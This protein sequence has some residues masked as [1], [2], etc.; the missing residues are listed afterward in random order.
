MKIALVLL[1]VLLGCSPLPQNAIEK[2]RTFET[3][4]SESFNNFTDIETPVKTVVFRWSVPAIHAIANERAIVE[5]WNDSTKNDYIRSLIDEHIGD[6]DDSIT[7]LIS[8]WNQDWP[9]EP[10]MMMSAGGLPKPLIPGSMMPCQSVYVGDISQHI[11]LEN[12]RGVRLKP[13][14]VSAPRHLYLSTE[15]TLWAKFLIGTGSF[16]WTSFSKEISLIIDVEPKPIKFR[17]K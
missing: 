13:L 15:E 17:V 14:A 3:L 6:A 5:K 1:T 7:Y 12:E 9:C 8:L 4:L 11:Y 10:P 2:E 16:N